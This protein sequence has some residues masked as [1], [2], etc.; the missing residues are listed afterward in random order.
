[1]TST[2]SFCTC[3]AAVTRPPSCAQRTASSMALERQLLCLQRR[4]RL[5]DRPHTAARKAARERVREAA[6]AL[7]NLRERVLHAP[8][9]LEVALHARAGPSDAPGAGPAA[10][11]RSRA[12]RTGSSCAST[13]TAPPIVPASME[14]VATASSSPCVITSALR[15][16]S[17]AVSQALRRAAGHTRGGR[18]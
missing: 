11:R 1:M 8:Q 3:G 13:M 10:G 9:E 18:R 15:Q 6:D 2:P 5:G 4:R 14:G 17:G 7:H 12:A 16:R